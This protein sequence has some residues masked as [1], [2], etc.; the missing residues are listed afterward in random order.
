M[1][2]AV[3]GNHGLDKIEEWVKEKFSPI[4]NKNVEVPTLVDPH[5]FPKGSLG[6][7]VKIVPVQDK[8]LITFEF[9]LPY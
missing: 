5:P 4:V 8:D 9:T 7:L 6:K 1:T 2:L 3:M